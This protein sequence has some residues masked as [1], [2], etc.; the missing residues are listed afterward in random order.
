MQDMC[1]KITLTML[2]GR[3]LS[4]LRIPHIIYNAVGLLDAPTDSVIDNGIIYKL[5][6]L[7]FFMVKVYYLV[8]TSF[9]AHLTF[10]PCELL[11]SLFICRPST[12][13]ILI[14]SSKTTGPIATKLWWNGL[15]VAP[16][17]IV[18]GDPDFQPRW[19]SS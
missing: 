6:C 5:I 11:P 12:F 1:R 9:L 2:K 7:I 18:S 3:R 10:R 16:F 14:F 19:P 4:T 8:S 15:W 17:K 13:H